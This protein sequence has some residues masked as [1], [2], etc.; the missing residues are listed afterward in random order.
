MVNRDIP[1]LIEVEFDNEPYP[2][3]NFYNEGDDVVFRDYS[4][5]GYMLAFD[6]EDCF[7]MT[8]RVDN[9]ETH[10]I[11]LLYARE[12]ARNLYDMW[13]EERSLYGRKKK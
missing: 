3:E 4:K 10:M 13:F 2:L 6:F 12:H 9:K 5:Q 11:N 8:Q 1:E 7:I